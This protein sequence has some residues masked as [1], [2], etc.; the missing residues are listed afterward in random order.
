M[1]AEKHLKSFQ[2]AGADD[3]EN[4][5]DD[6]DSQDGADGDG[7]GEKETQS[8]IQLLCYRCTDTRRAV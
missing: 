3:D 6:S 7:A 2:S 8:D 5:D 1:R 4:F